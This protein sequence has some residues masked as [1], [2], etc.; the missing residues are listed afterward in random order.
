MIRMGKNADSSLSMESDKTGG[1]GTLTFDAATFGADEDAK[2][3]VELSTD[4]GQSWKSVGAVT[5]SGKTVK[6]YSLPVKQAGTLL[7]AVRQALAY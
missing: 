6:E 5:V 4:G 3:N 2:L 7:S 1:I